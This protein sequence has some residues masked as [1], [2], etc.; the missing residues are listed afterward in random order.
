MKYIFMPASILV[1][2]SILV[3]CASAKKSGKSETISR[4]DE[5]IVFENNTM[6]DPASNYKWKYFDDNPTTYYRFKLNNANLLGKLPSVEQINAFVQK[7]AYQLDSKKYKEEIAKSGWFDND[8]K[9]LTSSFERTNEGEVRYEVLHWNSTT[10]SSS[11]EF[12]TG[13]DLVVVLL[14][15]EN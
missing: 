13:G 8:C 1:L 5:M 11:S 15:N 2:V 12:V 9:F 10:R 14:L 3:S 4:D 7:V 6:T